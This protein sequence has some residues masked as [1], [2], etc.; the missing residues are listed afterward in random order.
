MISAHRRATCAAP[1]SASLP[2][3]VAGCVIKDQTNDIEGK[4]LTSNSDAKF[5][6]DRPF[7][8]AKSGVEGPHC[9]PARP[10]A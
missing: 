3:P 6:T 7:F 1:R 2:A 10:P 9:P 5:V 8:R 4:K